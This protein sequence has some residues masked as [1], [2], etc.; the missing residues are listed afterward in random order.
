MGF[1]LPPG[2]GEEAG[3]EADRPAQRLRSDDGGPAW[4]AHHQ[5]QAQPAQEGQQQ[6]WQVGWQLSA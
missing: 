2:F 5:P 3:L 4:A 6:H 1:E